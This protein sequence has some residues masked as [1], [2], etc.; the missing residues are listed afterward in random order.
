[1]SAGYSFYNRGPRL[2]LKALSTISSSGQGKTSLFTSLNRFYGINFHNADAELIYDYV[3]EPASHATDAG[4]NTKAFTVPSEDPDRDG[5]F[6]VHAHG[7]PYLNIGTDLSGAGP[8]EEYAIMVLMKP[9]E[10]KDD[11]DIRFM[12]NRRLTRM[13]EEGFIGLP[14]EEHMR[15]R[16]NIGDT[17]AEK[18]FEN[19]KE[20][21]KK[22]VSIQLTTCKAGA[23]S[24][25]YKMY[26]AQ[27]LADRLDRCIL[28]TNGNMVC[29]LIYDYDDDANIVF[30]HSNRLPP[31]E[32]DAEWRLFVPGGAEFLE[33]QGYKKGTEYIVVGAHE[34]KDLT[35]ATDAAD[36]ILKKLGLDY[37]TIQ[38]K[39]SSD[40]A[41]KE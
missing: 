13:L 9:S 23:Y 10:N 4:F 3:Y 21:L 8:N 28:C 38:S 30:T 5:W 22:G 16:E 15:L 36:I 2:N 34:L 27:D 1:M 31:N 29:K 24:K 25:D 7:N 6:S 32:K 17:A 26:L 40:D 37:E 20:G 18:V 12:G 39:K 11:V 14:I 19:L 35:E 33:K 41:K